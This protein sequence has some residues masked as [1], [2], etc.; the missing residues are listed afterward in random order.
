MFHTRLG[1][2][3]IIKKTIILRADTN[4]YYNQF[5]RIMSSRQENPGM[6]AKKLPGAQDTRIKVKSNDEFY[7][8]LDLSDEDHTDHN[9][10]PVFDDVLRTFSNV[11]GHFMFDSEKKLDTNNEKAEHYLKISLFN[12]DSKLLQ[13][14]LNT[15]PFHEKIEI[16][17][18]IFTTT[19]LEEQERL[20]SDKEELYRDFCENRKRTVAVKHSS[21]SC[22][23]PPIEKAKQ[24]EKK[25]TTCETSSFIDSLDNAKSFAV[26]QTS[27]TP[28]FEQETKE[29][30]Q[31]WLDNLFS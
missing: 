20:A 14:A 7:P 10:A 1:P 3:P 24:N 21:K 17:P 22:C 23:L 4:C 26:L 6:K 5:H 30:M 18:N 27:E 12:V 29:N 25:G 2:I 11:G 8:D 28:S 19:A 31:N 16:N 15:I 13:R 9:S